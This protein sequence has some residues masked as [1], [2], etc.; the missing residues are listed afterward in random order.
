MSDM[1]MILLVNDGDMA[2]GYFRVSTTKEATFNRLCK[3]I[4][5]KDKLLELKE[6]KS[7]EGKTVCWNMKLPRKMLSVTSFGVKK[8]KGLGV[9][10]GLDNSSLKRLTAL[11]SQT[12]N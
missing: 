10:K 3:R 5:G 12:Q 4:G 1:E 9:G 2:E 8:I 6:S 11:R 7:S